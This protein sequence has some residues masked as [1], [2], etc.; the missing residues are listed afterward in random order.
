MATEEG[1]ACCVEVVEHPTANRAAK[2][3]S[4]NFS[5]LIPRATKSVRFKYNGQYDKSTVHNV[6]IIRRSP[7]YNETASLS[8]D[9]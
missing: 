7:P 8:T 9:P 6:P 2:L 5:H 3:R 4:G 1:A